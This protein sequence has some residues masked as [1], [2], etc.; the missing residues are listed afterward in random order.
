MTI[1]SIIAEC[2][3]R[4]GLDNFVNNEQKTADEQK[5][6]DRLLFNVNLVYREI[7]SAYLPLVETREVEIVDGEFAFSAL[8]NVRILYPIRIEVGDKEIKFKS[9]PTKLKCEYTGG[10][11][12]TYAYLPSTDFVITDTI[13]DAR[14]TAAIVATGVLAEYYFQNKVFDLAKSFDSDFRSGMAR[15]KYQGRQMFL[16]ERR[17]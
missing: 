14:I 2:L 4:M 10:A 12:L 1:K 7:V 17:W 5:I 16:K 13:D 3:V 11:K 15:I 8:D 9:Y 6:I